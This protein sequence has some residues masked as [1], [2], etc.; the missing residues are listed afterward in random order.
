MSVSDYS[1]VS[2]VAELFGEFAA[3]ELPSNNHSNALAA[4]L[5]AYTGPAYLVAFTVNNTN[6]AAQFIQLHDANALPADGAVPAVVFTA[7]ASSDKFVSYSLPGRFFLR[8]IVVCNSSTA[9]TK[10]IGAADCFFDVQ[11]I[12]IVR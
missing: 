1:G 9:A 2:P 5:V 10:T 12:P 11:I 4:S 8:G 6:A 7:P 3:S